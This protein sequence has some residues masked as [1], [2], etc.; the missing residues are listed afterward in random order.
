MFHDMTNW[1]T[2]ALACLG[3]AA[4]AQL[5][6]AE[7]GPGLPDLPLVRID[8]TPE[9]LG[10]YRGRVLLLVNVASRCGFTPQYA[11]LQQLHE[12]YADRGFAVLAFPSN[13]FAG[14]EPGSNAEIAE[15]CRAT[16]A[17]GF[18]MFEKLHVQ[19]PEQHPL[20]AHLTRLPAPL[21]G[22]VSWNFQKY[23]VDRDGRVVERLAPAVAPLDA[24]LVE[25]IEG[26][27]GA[28]AGEAPASP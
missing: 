26:L 2:A 28:E 9:P 8:G 4:T 19:G 17:V 3:L 18:P 25:R 21:G 13:D 1:T 16:Y 7:P 20:Y 22:P 24:K 11:G 5:T 14:Q 10:A 12:R 6:R 23:L 15:F 27:L